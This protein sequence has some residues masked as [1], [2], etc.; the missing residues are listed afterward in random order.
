MTTTSSQDKQI[1]AST[2]PRGDK[3]ERVFALSLDKESIT[4]DPGTTWAH[5]DRYKW[6][7]RGLIEE[8]QMLHVFPDGSLEINSEKIHITDPAATA[9]LEHQINKR[10]PPVGSHA[11]TPA[12]PLAVKAASTL[13]ADLRRFRVKL[14]HFGHLMI[15]WG[16]GTDREETG[17]RGV[18]SLITNGR[19]RKPEHYRV[20][21]MQRSIE[22][23]GVTYECN[24]AG[25]RKLEAA[26]N[27]YYAPRAEERQAAAI[28]VKEN[29][30]ASTGFDLRF[31]ITHAGVTHDI[32]GHLTQELLDQ[33]QDPAKSDLIQPGIHL[34]L[35]PPN[36]LIRRRR[37]DMGEDKIPELPD[38]NLLKLTSVQLQQIFN[39]P[40]IRRGD[41][42][43]AAPA[44]PAATGQSEA[45]VELRVIRNPEDK[46]F[47]W[48]ECVTNLGQTLAPRA[49]THHNIADLQNSGCFLPHLRVGLSLNHQR[50][51]IHDLQ[52]HKEESITLEPVN[53]PA[54]VLGEA[55]RMLTQALKRSA[56]AAT[57]DLVPTK[58]AA[59][60]E[61]QTPQFIP[62]AAAFA[63]PTQTGEAEPPTLRD[64]LPSPPIPVL[65]LD[66]DIVEL[67]R[68]T[69]ALHINQ[70]VFR[71]LSIHLGIAPQDIRLSLPLI[72]DNRRFEILNFD[73][74]EITS[75]MELR[76]TDFYGFYL[77]HVNE[78]KI[79]LVYACN[80]MHLE[81]GPDKCLL[82]ATIKSEAEEY[83]G[84]VLLGMAQDRNNEFVFVVDPEFKKWIAPREMPYTD[85]NLQFL[86]VADIAAAPDNYTLIWPQRPAPGG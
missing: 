86:T 76:G 70:E 78:K 54:E 34:L 12:S 2:R 64:A 20:D 57:S 69:D 37:P 24:E 8:P 9:K 65:P 50:L 53:N 23:D 39:H 66:P 27:S 36:L 73:R 80:G 29:L 49:L 71:R 67:F 32:K 11:A 55:S 45:I 22:I 38:V 52:T 10:H 13:A 56:P 46:K 33:L 79:M 4:L 82:Q 5:A 47:L 19:I 48:V 75:V 51:S 30:A 83:R 62:P 40:L 44:Q 17:L 31:R 63:P 72:F 59:V 25:A 14:D 18:A 84:R 1:R 58:A 21:P 42:S 68:P 74:Q 26:L 81:W 85:E 77:S 60:S 61:E 7:V 41:G 15:E 43:A 28:E 35:S 6:V 3:G 16:H